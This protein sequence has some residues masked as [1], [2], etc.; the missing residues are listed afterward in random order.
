MNNTCILRLGGYHRDNPEL[1]STYSREKRRMA[2]LTELD[3]DDDDNNN[4]KGERT[5]M[6][7]LCFKE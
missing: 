7:Q 2:G 1:I 6:S 4:I 3:E 5:N